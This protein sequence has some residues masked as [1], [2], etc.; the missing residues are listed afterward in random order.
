MPNQYTER[1]ALNQHGIGINAQSDDSL[2]D[3]A[4]ANGVVS[5]CLGCGTIV[6]VA[7]GTDERTRAR[8]ARTFDFSCCDDSDDILY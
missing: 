4:R 6:C 8:M 7:P 1:Q 3:T 5:V 2:T